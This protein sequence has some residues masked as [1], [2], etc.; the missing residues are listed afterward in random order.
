MESQQARQ[1]FILSLRERA[2]VRGKETLQIQ[3]HPKAPQPKG[4]RTNH[5]PF[6]CSKHAFSP[7]LHEPNGCPS[8]IVNLPLFKIDCFGRRMVDLK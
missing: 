7:A 6:K 1:S 5:H 2:G 4:L 8:N 3:T